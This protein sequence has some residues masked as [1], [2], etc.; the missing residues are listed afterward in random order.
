VIWRKL[1][2]LKPSLQKVQAAHL[3]ERRLKPVPAP[4]GR[5]IINLLQSSG[6]LERCP[7]GAFKEMNGTPK[8]R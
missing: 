6:A 3:P 2:C 5:V 8:S 4:C 1:D 7:V